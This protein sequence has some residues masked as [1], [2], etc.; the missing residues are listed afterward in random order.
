MAFQDVA[1]KII[2]I[3]IYLAIGW[4]V[5]MIGLSI[6]FNNLRSSACNDSKS[7]A[8]TAMNQVSVSW[9]SSS[10]FSGRATNR[11]TEYIYGFTASSETKDCTATGCVVVDRDYASIQLSIPPG[12]AR[13]FTYSPG[14]RSSFG[15][16]SSSPVIRGTPSVER[17]IT[18][19]DVVG[20][21]R[22]PCDR[23]EK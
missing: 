3:A 14:L 13:D 7:K 23:D 12:E 15:N 8:A 18:S 11:G 9:D 22:D 21:G 4:V 10:G 20:A 1:K 2:K 5:L 17:K 6:F 16:T 19:V